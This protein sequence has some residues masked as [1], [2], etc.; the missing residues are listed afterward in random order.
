MIEVRDYSDNGKDEDLR[1]TI[2]TD[3]EVGYLTLSDKYLAAISKDGCYISVY[4]MDDTAQKTLQPYQKFIRGQSSSVV[5]QPSQFIKI[6]NEDY[7]M[8]S[9]DGMTTHYFAIQKQ[10]L[11][12][13]SS[14]L[15][16]SA[17]LPSA[18]TCDRSVKKMNMNEELGIPESQIEPYICFNEP[19]GMIVVI[20]HG[21]WCLKYSP[22]KVTVKDSDAPIDLKLNLKFKIKDF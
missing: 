20:T 5:Y 22:S 12:Q 7:F 14:T 19:S 18:L 10:K 6:A 11:E 15:W 21:G 17:I 3:F 2:T 9:S 8:L 16:F 13:S 1:S 4:K